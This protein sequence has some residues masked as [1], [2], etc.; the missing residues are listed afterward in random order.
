MP[1]WTGS[2]AVV[3]RCSMT[4]AAGLVLACLTVLAGA[5]PAAAPDSGRDPLSANLDL[6]SS[7]QPSVAFPTVTDVATDV[8]SASQARTTKVDAAATTSAACDGCVGTPETLQAVYLRHADTV[9]ADNSAI[10]WSQQCTGCSA[11]AVSIQI[12]VAPA[13]STLVANNRALAMN[14]QCEGCNTTA[15]AYQIVLADSDQTLSTSARDELRSLMSSLRRELGDERQLAQQDNAATQEKR[16]ASS[17]LSRIERIVTV[18]LGT[19]V[20]AKRAAVDLGR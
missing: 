18:D 8:V 17:G 11:N 20:V 14:L 7:A 1:I 9:K 16:L 13:A 12:I 15:A 6:L 2:R 10:A 5:T 19:R 4:I 3:R